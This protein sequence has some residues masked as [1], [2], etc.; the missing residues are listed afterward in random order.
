VP[1]RESASYYMIVVSPVPRASDLV[2]AA[3]IVESLL[4]HK[5]WIFSERSPGIKHFKIG[6]KLIIY[7]G[8]GP[9]RT[10]RPGRFVAYATLASTPTPIRSA[11]RRRID[12]LGLV[13]FMSYVVLSDVR[14]IEPPVLITD[15]W[16]DSISS[17]TRKTMACG[18]A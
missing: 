14:R 3:T 9:R 13:W 6:D 7:T 1:N 12:R 16:T 15:I 10:Q 18:S 11:L 4:S 2:P 17:K 5:V 8:A